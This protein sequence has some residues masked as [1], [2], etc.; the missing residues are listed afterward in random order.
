M[1]YRRI[2]TRRCLYSTSTRP[3]P[4]PEGCTLSREK[5]RALIHIYHDAKDFITHENL[6]SR[7]D[8]AFA[9]KDQIR[10]N[11]ARDLAELRDEVQLRYG[12]SAFG[13]GHEFG[14]RTHQGKTWSDGG[15]SERNVAVKAA[16]WGTSDNGYSVPG[17][18]IVEEEG[19]AS[20]KIKKHML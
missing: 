1:I 5:L 13:V 8:L 3:Q 2:L 16:L 15:R 20:A 11:Q 12:A 10:R 4:P 19:K 14:G 9:L 18:E 7:I 6:D 17:L